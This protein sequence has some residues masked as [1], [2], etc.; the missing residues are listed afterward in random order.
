MKRHLV[1]IA[2]LATL[3]TACGSDQ[4]ETVISTPIV[5]ALSTEEQSAE[6]PTAESSPTTKP[7]PTPSPIPA[8]VTEEATMEP[9]PTPTATTQPTR[10]PTSTA[11]ATATAVPPTITPAPTVTP[12][13]API[14]DASG[15]DQA[16]LFASLLTIGDMPTGWTGGA[17]VFEPRTPGGTYNSFCTELPA[18]SIAAAYVEFEKSAFG[19]FLTHSIVVYPDSASARAA[20]DDLANAA[21]NCTQVTD[22]SGSTNTI[23]PLSFPSLGED[24]FAVRSSGTVEMDAIYILVDNLL[25]TITHGGLGAVDSAVTESSART[26]VDRYGR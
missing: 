7:L 4:A 21:Q 14:A 6:T 22:G 2:L 9:S 10:T 18:R 17:A 13:Q 24:T 16:A 15:V 23:S 3:L 20:L 1:L 11:T 25:L 26:A 5:A 12:T 19:P 8:T